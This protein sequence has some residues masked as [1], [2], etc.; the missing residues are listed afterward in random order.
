MK[1]TP[2]FPSGLAFLTISAMLL[3]VLAVPA[4]ARA[5]DPLPSWNDGPAKQA[6]VEFVRTTT[7]ASSPQFVPTEKRIATFDQDGT[8]WV[9]KPM[10]PQLAYCLDRVSAVA[11]KK[12]ELKNVEPFKTVLSG[13]RAAIAKLTMPDLEKIAR[14]HA[15]RHHDGSI[16]GRSEAVARDGQGPAL[17]KALQRA[18]LPADAGGAEVSSRQRL[19]DLHRQRRRPGL[20]SRLRRADLRHPARAGRR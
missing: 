16:S 3:V 8:L 5:E 13:D 17:E 9:E 20:H 1:K 14:R 12:P 15:H 7:D 10:V 2:R 18:D 11:E 19:Q 4:T 6:I